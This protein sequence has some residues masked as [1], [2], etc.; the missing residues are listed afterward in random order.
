[1]VIISKVSKMKYS[2]K[3]KSAGVA[4]MGL[5][6]SLGIS[7]YAKAQLSLTYE[8]TLSGHTIGEAYSGPFRINL[9][10]FDMGALYPALGATGTAIGYGA[11]GTG[12]QSVAGGI[13]TL[14]AAQ[15]AGAVGAKPGEDS[16][17]VARILTITDLAGSVVWSEAAKNAQLTVMF[18]GEQDF[19]VNQLANGFQEIDGTGLH[20]DLYL[21]SKA[22]PGYTQ[23]NPLPGS[24]GRS[25]LNDHDYATVTD[26]TQILTTVATGGFLHPNGTLGGLATAFASI[27]N[28][29]SGGTG[30]TYLSVT[31]GTDASRFDTNSFTSDFVPGATADLFAQFTTTINDPAVGDWLVRSNDPV[32]G[33]FTAVPEPSTY[34]LIGAAALAGIIALRR[35]RQARA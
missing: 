32:S 14:N 21:Q 7:P 29:S 26:G 4:L 20:V 17:G 24:S 6:A 2:T 9:Q 30:Q 19:Y 18:Y 28:A 8:D 13:S 34:G 1:L 33:L 5:I 11:G 22:A 10:N 16:W 23:Y 31:G 27:F 25:L 35:R 3:T 12:T 15:T